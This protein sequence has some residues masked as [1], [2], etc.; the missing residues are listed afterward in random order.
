[1]FLPNWNMFQQYDRDWHKSTGA[2]AEA[3]SHVGHNMVAVYPGSTTNLSAVYLQDTTTL[4]SSGDAFNLG[5]HDLAIVYD[6][7]EII[8]LTHLRMYPECS[9]KVEKFQKDVLPYIEGGQWV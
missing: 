9:R 6:L 8:L 3:W 5:D 7:C 4:N 1:M 2:R